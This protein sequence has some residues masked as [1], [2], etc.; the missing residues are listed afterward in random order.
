MLDVHF[1]IWLKKSANPLGQLICVDFELITEVREPQQGGGRVTEGTNSSLPG[2]RRLSGPH[3][4]PFLPGQVR[5]PVHARALSGSRNPQVALAA[6]W[7]L[8]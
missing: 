4:P 7:S 5:H 6:V 3:S 8:P 1:V 2:S